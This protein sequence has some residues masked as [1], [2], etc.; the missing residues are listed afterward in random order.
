MAK[1]LT[2]TAPPGTRMRMTAAI[3]TPIESTARKPV[4][5][6]AATASILAWPNG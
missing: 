6:S 4:S 3:A 2:S 1:A 5:A